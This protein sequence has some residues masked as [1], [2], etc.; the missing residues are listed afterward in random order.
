MR[1]ELPA[2]DAVKN[3]ENVDTTHGILR[4]IVPELVVAEEAVPGRQIKQFPRLLTTS[5]NDTSSVS[6]LR[7][8]SKLNIIFIK[9]YQT[10]SPLFI[11]Y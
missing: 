2:D 1:T 9:Q 5:G 6:I 4:C 10:S 11:L 3:Y 7:Y 8:A